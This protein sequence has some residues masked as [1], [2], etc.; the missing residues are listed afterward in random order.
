MKSIKC[1]ILAAAALVS[2][3]LIHPANAAVEYVRICSL[4]GAGWFYYPGSD[5][6][7]NLYTGETRK[8]T[9]D[10]VFSSLVTRSP[11]YWVMRPELACLGRVQW[12]GTFRPADLTLNTVTAAYE[13]RTVPFTLG[14]KEFISSLMMSG[15]FGDP[16]KGFC[17]SVKDSG[18]KS[19]VLGCADMTSL[20]GSP[21][22]WQIS[23]VRSTPPTTF[24]A[25]FSFMGSN[26]DV[27]WS[28]LPATGSITLSACI[29]SV[30]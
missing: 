22:T 23:P 4:Y 30:L 15:G 17:I 13:T 19:Q 5:S 10:G 25:P 6:C 14:K 11:G 26:A 21:A 27:K 28:S 1:A 7:V 18:G 12:I 24:T 9:E 8:A 3:S 2:G 16:A 29:Q 20:I